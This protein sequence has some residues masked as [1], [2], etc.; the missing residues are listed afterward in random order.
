LNKSMLYSKSRIIFPS[1]F[2]KKAENIHNH[3]IHVL[4]RHSLDQAK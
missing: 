3:N 1:S 4:E 2:R